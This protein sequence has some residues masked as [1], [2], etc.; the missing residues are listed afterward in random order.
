VNRGDAAFGR[1]R[2]SLLLAE[3]LPEFLPRRTRW[4]GVT[5]LPG[6]EFGFLG[7]RVRTW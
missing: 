6:K 3:L 7:E 5:G 2:S 1:R 4:V